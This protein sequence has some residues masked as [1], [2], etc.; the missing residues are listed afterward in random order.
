MSE[1]SV[2]RKSIDTVAKPGDLFIMRT[3]QEG[4]ELELLTVS[5]LDDER[6]SALGLMVSVDFELL[7]YYDE[8]C[9]PRT[10]TFLPSIKI[11]ELARHLHRIFDHD[12]FYVGRISAI[13][14]LELLH[15]W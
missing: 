14:K 9:K 2:V 1:F 15:R 8:D 3:F 5:L 7:T 11:E 10:L 12:V 6:K 13:N 4:V